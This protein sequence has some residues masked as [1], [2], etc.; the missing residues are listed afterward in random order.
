MQTSEQ[1]DLLAPALLAAQRAITAAAKSAEN[2]EFGRRYA[3]LPAV[4]EAV[5]GPLNDA[6]ITYVQGSM[7]AGPGVVCI[8]TRL[9]H[10]SGQWI[11]SAVA[12]PLFQQD[13]QGGMSAITY[14]RRAGL[15]AITGLRQADDDGAA[16]MPK[17]EG[18]A[19]P[20]AKAPTNGAITEAQAKL[21]RNKVSRAK[22]DQKALLTHY[23]IE[24][25]EDLPADK[26]NECIA[27]LDKKIT[28]AAAK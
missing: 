20:A 8:T 2:E 22:A 11:Q 1:I 23:G 25:L 26:L 15:S 14:A 13:P 7:D 17:K 6:G 12:L 21:L 9:I 4:I 18:K 16:A 10:Q 19:T 24:K 27:S 28:K 3:D 5:K